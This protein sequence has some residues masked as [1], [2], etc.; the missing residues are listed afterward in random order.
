MDPSKL[1]VPSGLE[2]KKW[3]GEKE[4]TK[5]KTKLK[6]TGVRRFI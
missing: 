3:G 4:R 5:K 6:V 2:E 1:T